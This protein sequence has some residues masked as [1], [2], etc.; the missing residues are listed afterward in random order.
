MKDKEKE[1][2]E[3]KKRKANLMKVLSFTE[4]EESMQSILAVV[5][6]LDKELKRADIEL[7]KAHIKAQRENQSISFEMIKK[8]ISGL[9]ETTLGRNL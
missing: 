4:D 1:L 3:V 7:D 5:K 2:R 6:D 9:K 8:G